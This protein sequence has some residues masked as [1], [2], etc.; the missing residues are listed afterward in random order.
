M[1]RSQALRVGV[2]SHNTS[3][4]VSL[5]LQGHG[6]E[7]VR[8]TD[9]SN[10]TDV[11]V[12]FLDL[13]SVQAADEWLERLPENAPCVL[14][15]L[16]SEDDRVVGSIRRPYSVGELLAALADAVVANM[17]R[18][19]AHDHVTDLVGAAEEQPTAEEAS[20]H[21]AA[22]LVVDDTVD[23]VDGSASELASP[24]GSRSSALAV[25]GE[26]LFVA[27]ALP[28]A[29][30]SR[31]PI[32]SVPSVRSDPVA[33]VAAI[34][35]ELR[36]LLEDAPYLL[37]VARLAD[38]IA[39]ALA[40]ESGAANVALWGDAGAHLELLGSNGLTDGERRMTPNRRH[41][42]LE[43][44]RRQG[45]LVWED[46]DAGGLFTAGLPGTHM[47]SFA[48]AVVR[49][50]SVP[51]DVVTAGSGGDLSG[52]LVLVDDL[53]AEAVGAWRAAREVEGL[54]QRLPH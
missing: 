13:P 7:V 44:A 49:D 10:I 33:R 15:G 32:D 12:V 17:A 8:F 43:E 52:I 31:T 34:A 29:P 40:S 21:P 51:V 26:R 3:L 19:D 35:D 27:R 14:A 23:L 24:A 37:S 25:R 11:D 50:T 42:M 4:F 20:T 22:A 2:V 16:Q 18:P 54:R 6:T 39:I 1:G 47:R 36:A 28:Q 30:S 41:P 38:A 46:L 48:V 45:G 5:S 53:L 9:S